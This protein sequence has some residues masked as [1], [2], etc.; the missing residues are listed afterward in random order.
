[1]RSYLKAN[2]SLISRSHQPRSPSILTTS[3]S[4]TTMT[5]ESPQSNQV[6]SQTSMP[7][8]PVPP[9]E[10]TTKRY[11]Q[12]LV[13]FL[14]Q[15]AQASDKPQEHFEREY[16]LRQTWANELCAEGGLGNRLQDR[17]IDVDRSSPHNWLDDNYW[18]QIAYHS[19][20]NPL[21]IHSN[22]WILLQPDLSIPHHVLQSIPQ[23]GRFTDWQ[24]RRA[25]V[26]VHRFMIFKQKLDRYVSLLP[27]LKLLSRC[28]GVGSF[29]FE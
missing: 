27:T 28:F 20:R 4:F 1:M 23:Q 9:L 21:P 19:N 17:L 5:S 8:L 7:R 16:R 24:L 11:L 14:L 15:S 10:Q 29:F 6:R 26:L 3:F 22:W 25:S 12:S 2:L 13:P 18:I